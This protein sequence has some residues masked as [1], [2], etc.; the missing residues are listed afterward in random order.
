MAFPVPD[1][2]VVPSDAVSVGTAS[3][4][5]VMLL[6]LQPQAYSSFKE[7]C[8]CRHRRIHHSKSVVP[9]GIG[10]FIMQR[11]LCLQAQAYSSCKARCACRHKRIHHAWRKLILLQYIG[12][13][14]RVVLAITSTKSTRWSI[15]NVWRITISQ[16]LLKSIVISSLGKDIFTRIHLSKKIPSTRTN[17]SKRFNLL[18]FHINT[19][20]LKLSVTKRSQSLTN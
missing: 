12:Q 18:V 8:A 17:S 9:A 3:F 19:Y 7:C 14:M 2:F 5:V 11:V 10:I 16:W 4:I 13:K 6:W 15:C 20:S 1:I